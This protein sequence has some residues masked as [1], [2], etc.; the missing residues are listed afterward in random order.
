[1]NQHL[2]PPNGPTVGGVA[3][4]SLLIPYLMVSLSATIGRSG[5]RF[6]LQKRRQRCHSAH[7]VRFRL[8]ETV[9]CPHERHHAAS[10]PSRTVGARCRL[11]GPFDTGGGSATGETGESGRTVQPGDASGHERD[12]HSG[13]NTLLTSSGGCNNP[14]WIEATFGSPFFRAS[15]RGNCETKNNEFDVHNFH[16]DCH[17]AGSWWWHRERVWR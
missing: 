10:P 4:T 14:V 12:H 7:H 6:Y 11:H 8:P 5:P 13:S 1:M 15:L 17:G 16:V 3:V 2:T 9:R